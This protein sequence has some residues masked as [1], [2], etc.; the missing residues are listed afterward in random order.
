MHQAFA[1]FSSCNQARYTLFRYIRTR[2]AAAVNI[3]E[4]NL[5]PTSP[6]YKTPTYSPPARLFIAKAT[7][8]YGI[9]LFLLS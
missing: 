4:Y 2:K 5:W 9:S 6:V 7:P 3:I 1:I 8:R